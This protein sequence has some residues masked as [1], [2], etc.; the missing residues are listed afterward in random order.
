[1]ENGR[2]DWPEAWVGAGEGG[3]GG[4][5]LLSDVL[6]PV[7]V[8]EGELGLDGFLGGIPDEVVVEHDGLDEL[9]L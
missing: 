9:V 2:E 7:L 6:G 8:P 5:G 1:M 4:G 3:E